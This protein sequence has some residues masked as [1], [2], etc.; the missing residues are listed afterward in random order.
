[1]RYLRSLGLALL[2]LFIG[3]PVMVESAAP[4]PDDGTILVDRGPPVMDGTFAWDL[5]M[6][7]LHHVDGFILTG[8][9][10]FAAPSSSPLALGV[11]LGGTSEPLV[12]RERLR[13]SIMG[14]MTYAGASSGIYLPGAGA[15]VQG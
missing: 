1:M 14:R 15:G 13:H 8:P 9:E 3:L 11:S 2:L 4:F 10:T 5:K 12:L 6:T 7:A